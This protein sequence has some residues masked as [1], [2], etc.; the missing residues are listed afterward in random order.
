MPFVGNWRLGHR[1]NV[2]F[3]WVMLAGVGLL[4]FQAAKADRNN[5]NYL[6]AIRSAERD[7]ERVIEL[8]QSPAGIPPTGAVTLLRDDPLTQGPKLFAKNCASCHR[9]DGHDGLGGQPKDKISASDL[10]G[11]ASREWLTGLLDP[12]K[13][14][15]AHYFG[16]TKFKNSKMVKFVKEEIGSWND[17]RKKQL[18]KAVAALSAEAHLKGQHN[19]DQRDAALIEE[20]GKLLGGDTL[21]CIDC[22]KFHEAGDDDSS[23]PDLSS[24]GSRDWLVAF[25]SNPKHDRF[26][27]SRNDRMPAFG[28][29]KMLTNQEIGLVVD[30]LRG[31]WYEP[32]PVAKAQ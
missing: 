1:F 6:V 8:A 29:E 31:E 15:S 10:K 25:V 23:G 26:Y 11:Y 3:L 28:E 16:G 19:L 17:D 27:R 32:E 21:G 9:Y 7:A 5:P 18:G 24:Y 22:H 30:W 14:D 20:G 12:Q 4:T 2:G 13:V